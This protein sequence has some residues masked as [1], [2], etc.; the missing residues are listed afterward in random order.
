MHGLQ[1]VRRDGKTRAPCA[2]MCTSMCGGGER[3]RAC[4]CFHR[5]LLPCNRLRAAGGCDT[6]DTCSDE[7]AD[8]GGVLL[9]R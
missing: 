4:P 7:N 3:Q 5:A 2:A 9:F 8:G 1:G 6:Y